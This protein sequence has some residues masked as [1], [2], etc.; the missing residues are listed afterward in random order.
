M[1]PLRNAPK[2][3]LT[4][5]YTFY[6]LL[7]KRKRFN[8]T[9]ILR[10]LK[11]KCEYRNCGKRIPDV[12]LIIDHKNHKNADT[13]WENIRVYCKKHHDVDIHGHIPKR[14]LR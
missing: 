3:D 2:S 6:F 4:A 14:L 7:G 9:S 1:L 13:R 8:Q 11:A 10:H 5:T 12:E